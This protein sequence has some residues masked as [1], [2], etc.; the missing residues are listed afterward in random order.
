MLNESISDPIIQILR[1]VSINPFI[2]DITH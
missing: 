2:I 1:L